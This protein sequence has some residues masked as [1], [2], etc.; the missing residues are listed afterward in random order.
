MD[1]LRLWRLVAVLHPSILWH[2][3]LTLVHPE[4]VLLCCW[5]P[6][7]ESLLRMINMHLLRVHHG[8]ILLHAIVLQRMHVARV[9]VVHLGT[10]H[11]VGIGLVHPLSLATHHQSV[12]KVLLLVSSLH[13][14]TFLSKSGVDP[15]LPRVLLLGQRIRHLQPD[16]VIFAFLCMNLLPFPSHLQTCDAI[17][18]PEHTLTAFMHLAF[19]LL[20]AIHTPLA[21]LYL[22]LLLKAFQLAFQVLVLLP[23]QSVV[24]VTL[25]AR[26]TAAAQD[27]VAFTVGRAVL[28]AQNLQSLL[29]HLRALDVLCLAPLCVQ[30]LCWF[31]FRPLIQSFITLHHLTFRVRLPVE[32]LLRALIGLKRR[33]LSSPCLTLIPWLLLPLFHSL[34]IRLGSMDTLLCLSFHAVLNYRHCG[35]SRL[36]VPHT[37]TCLRGSCRLLVGHLQQ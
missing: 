9:H 2:E 37:V 22:G 4:D 36:L 13:L 16:A 15:H 6:S 7:I 19:P 11:P 27:L 25:S 1:H 35:I 5:L 20:D 17:L 12:V 26:V 3:S 32:H 14:R 10:R 30:V 34:S 21:L 29:H 24:S 8:W 23:Q 18:H 28:T 31:A 33:R